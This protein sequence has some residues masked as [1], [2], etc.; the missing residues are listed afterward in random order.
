MS[1]PLFISKKFT[2]SRKESRFITII[3]S[4]SILGISLGVAT[5][6]IALSILEGFAETIQK[7]IIDLD[8]HIQITSYQTVLPNYK[9]VLP[10][11]RQILGTSAEVNPYAS[12]LV[13]ISSKH[14]KEGVNIKGIT[15]ENKS[16]NLEKNIIEGKLDLNNDS[17]PS[18]IVGK[19]LAD[20]LFVKLNDFV[21]VFALKNNEIP[22]IDNPPTIEQFKVKGIF[23]TGMA[24]YDD[25]IAYT[26][27]TC[28]QNL[29]GFGDK[30]T[31]YDIKLNDISKID[32]ISNLLASQLRYPHAVSSIFQKHRNIFTWIELQKKPIP[33]V[34][35]L[36]ILVAAFN[37]ISS[38]LMVV[39]E[40][41]HS[42]GVL[43]SLGAT[44]GQITKIFAYQ[45]VFLAIIGIIIGNLLALLLMSIQLHYNLISLPSSVYFTSTV[46]I[47]LSLK[48]FAGVSIIALLLC[49]A[50]AFIP[51]YIASKIKPISSLRF[52]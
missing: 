3:S 27:L 45:G 31:G 23:E 41:T 20:K 11:I 33:I 51:S 44:N 18:I 52:S 13:I 36:I 6:I 25:L 1:F 40:K 42:I 30:I 39:L 5:L 16:I 38:L 14:T 28:A 46:P 43:K 7:K 8:S 37:I 48:I 10:A 4:I 19:K 26:N 17:P 9:R 35:G 2:L 15:P 47:I 22:S 29:F 32:S 24:E 49:F 34:L 21:T 50:A 12:N